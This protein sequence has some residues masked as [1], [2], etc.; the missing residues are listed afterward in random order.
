MV[1]LLLFLV[2]FCLFL[3]ARLSRRVGDLEKQK[4]PVRAA[5]VSTVAPI[6]GHEASMQPMPQHEITAPEPQ[7]PDEEIATNWLTKIGVIALLFGVGFFLKYAIDQ[8][9]I[10][11]LT[12]AMMGVAIG[13]LLIILGEIWKTK[14][15]SYALSLTGGGIGILYFSAAA[16]YQFY[17]LISQGPAAAVMVLITLSASFLAYRYRSLSLAMLAA[18]GCFA[19]PL[20]LAS[21]TDRQ[22]QLFFYLTLLN[23]GILFV[24]IKKYWYEL[25]Y[26]AL[27]GTIIDFVAWGTAFSNKQNTLESMLFLLTSLSLF[28]V[29]SVLL[30]QLHESQK[31]LPEKADDTQSIFF[32]L[33][34]T[35]FVLAGVFLLY[36]NF[37]DRLA[38]V[39]FI[40]AIIAFVAYFLTAR[41]SWR[42]LRYVSSFAF[43]FLLLLF[44]NWQFDNN[45]LDAAIIVLGMSAVTAGVF[46]GK[47]ELRISGFIILMLGL[48]M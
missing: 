35:F 37:H 22:I 48:L 38:L 23:I 2:I 39:S 17:D 14:Y 29:I 3:I 27:I 44:A 12:R 47:Q 32:V 10:S 18:I 9:W 1:V 33:S 25:L 40:E 45:M 46:L 19:S 30:L 8:G 34:G 16:A 28:W 7:R 41:S 6:A 43:F 24:L 20:M 36:R 11:E 13:T 15:R 42:N 31:T 21:G 5:A 26:I 4:S